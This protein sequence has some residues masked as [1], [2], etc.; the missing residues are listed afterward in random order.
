M[1]NPYAPKSP[2]RV[3]GTFTQPTASDAQGAQDEPQDAGAVS[4]ADEGAAAATGES[5]ASVA[6]RAT[7]L[8]LDD[9]PDT[10]GDV[11]D[12]VTE[13]DDEEEAARR[14]AAAAEVELARDE[15]ERRKTVLRAVADEVEAI[16]GIRPD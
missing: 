13:P 1:G 16:T 6:D 10:A 5:S 2:R 11:V 3:K 8:P 4:T 12:W 7:G 15:G 14:R 9:V